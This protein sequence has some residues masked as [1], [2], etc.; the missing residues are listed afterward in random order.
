MV[1]FTSVTVSETVQSYRNTAII[2]TVTCLIGAS[3]FLL[4][5]ERMILGKIRALKGEE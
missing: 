4:Y 1:V 3:L 5:N 2:A